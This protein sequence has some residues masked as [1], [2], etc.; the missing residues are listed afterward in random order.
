MRGSQVP[1]P[2]SIAQAPTSPARHP[3]LNIYGVTVS[4]IWTSRAYSGSAR[5][6]DESRP[7][8]A[9]STR[10]RVP[11]EPWPSHDTGCCHWHGLGQVHDSCKHHGQRPP[12]RLDSFPSKRTEARDS[13]R[14]IDA[15]AGPSVFR[16]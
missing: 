9:L 11:A 3:S 14:A 6:A 15:A 5:P 12:D 1:C 10:L 16:G 4:C 8:A 7:R 2:S 13:C